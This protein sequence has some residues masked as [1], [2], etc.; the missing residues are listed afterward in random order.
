MEQEVEM[1]NSWKILFSILVL[2]AGL[3]LYIGWAAMYNAWTDVG[4]YAT[5][6]PIIAFGLAGLFLFTRKEP[7]EED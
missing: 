1:P 7:E 4:L 6:V 5:S 2:V 3:I